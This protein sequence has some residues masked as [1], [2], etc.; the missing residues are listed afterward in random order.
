MTRLVNIIGRATSASGDVVSA[1]TERAKAQATGESRR[2]EL[3]GG[4]YEVDPE[5]RGAVVP[6]VRML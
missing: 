6:E 2:R 5:Q 4:A 1:D 3:C